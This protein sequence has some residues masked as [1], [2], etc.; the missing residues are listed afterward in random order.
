MSYSTTW[1]IDHQIH[2]L[3]VLL[4]RMKELKEYIRPPGLVGRS[5]PSVDI[6]REVLVGCQD[7]DCIWLEADNLYVVPLT[8]F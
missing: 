4:G 2:W 1:N 7:E 6:Y 8:R 3:L 5:T